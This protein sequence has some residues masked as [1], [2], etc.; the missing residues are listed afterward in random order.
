MHILA[1]NFSTDAGKLSFGEGEISERNIIHMRKALAAIGGALAVLA[2][3][4]AGVAQADSTCPVSQ[5]CG[6]VAHDYP[7]D[8]NASRYLEVLDAYGIALP[9]DD[10]DDARRL[11]QTICSQRAKGATG[12]QLINHMV[13]TGGYN[14]TAT[15]NIVAMAEYHFCPDRFDIS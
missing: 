1:G 8:Q 13:N 10:A 7:G 15:V 6:N 5:L 14:L 11:G 9:S 4:P 12:Q 3:V 2:V